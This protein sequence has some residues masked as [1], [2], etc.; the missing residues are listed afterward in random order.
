MNVKVSS[1]NDSRSALRTALVAVLIVLFLLPL[2]WT[3]SLSIRPDSALFSQP[4]QW[5]FRAELDSYRTVLTDARVQKATLNSLI[6]SISTTLAVVAIG[7]PA[8]YSL[9]RYR[10]KRRD[11]ILLFVLAGRLVLPVVMLMPY[12][13]IFQELGL[14]STRI[15]LVIAYTAFNLPFFIWIMTVFAGELPAD[16]E[17]AAQVDGY[18]GWRMWRTTILPLLRPGLVATAVLVYIFTWSEL[19]FAAVV[20]GSD[21][22]TLPVVISRFITG[23]GVHWGELAAVATISVIPVIVLAAGL[24]KFIVRGLALGAVKG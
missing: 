23:S 8:A 9:A 19:A 15:G 4:P 10:L 20:G 16:L 6:L 2:L 17:T 13:I 5:F 21:V 12:F 7:T 22:E 14:R 3:L 1:R 24:H 11:D 18:S